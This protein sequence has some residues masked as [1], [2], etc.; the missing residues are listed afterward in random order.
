VAVFR[1]PL[2][3]E[4]PASKQALKLWNQ[5][6]AHREN[7]TAELTFGMIDP[8]AATQMVGQQTIYIS[9][10]LCAFGDA[11]CSGQDTSDYPWDTVPKVAER[12]FR[13]Q[14]YH[15]R[16]Q[17]QHRF[18]LSREER[19]SLP[20]PQDFLQPIVADA[21][22]GFGS[23]TTIV[24]LVQ[25][26][27]ESGVA[28]F[29][30]DDLAIGGKRFT[31]GEGPAVVPTSEYLARL[32]AA[33]LQLD[34][35]GLVHHIFKIY[36]KRSY[37]NGR[38]SAETLL[39]SRCDLDGSQFIT[40]N[41]DPRDH[42]YILGAT[43]EIEPLTD[44]LVS[45]GVRGEDKMREITTEWISRAGLMTFDDAV[46]AKATE[47]Q[48][49]KYLALL[50]QGRFHGLD[51]RRKYAR[52]AIEVE[53]PF[54]NWDLPR[55]PDGRYRFRPSRQAI[56]DRCLASVP[57]TD[58]TWARMDFVWQ[59]YLKVHQD[60]RAVY[61]ERLFA[62]GYSATYNFAAMGY[63][64]QEVKEFHLRLAKLGVVWQ[65]Q[66]GFAMQ[67]VNHFTKKFSETWSREGIAGYIREIQGPATQA[68]ADTYEKMSWSG[69]YLADAYQDI[70]QNTSRQ[71]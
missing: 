55:T 18:Q 14:R 36:M 69:G 29:H 43:N 34:I 6:N 33:R 15:D 22:M 53:P 20:A 9:G 27:V 37:I 67:G 56:V 7:A 32:S 16:R 17:R 50:A 40:S 3:V 47:G 42:A 8:I 61:P 44:V 30:I 48:F 70:V 24:K 12:M 46:K 41:I 71:L 59:D 11:E 64:E 62:A 68:N 51:A 2:D 19:E 26:L 60:I 49:A 66:P 31:K 63:S 23:T 54:F 38:L 65:L 52:E 35:M 21:D 39:M 13:S 28:M 57:L 58:V 10:A 45:T 5:L 25:R 1:S 4:F